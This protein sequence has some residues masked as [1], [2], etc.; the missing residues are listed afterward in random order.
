M[1]KG[2]SYFSTEIFHGPL[3]KNTTALNRE[4]LKEVVK[5]RDI[6]SAG[7]RWSKKNYPQGYTSYSSMSELFRVSSTFLKLK[8]IIDRQVKAYASELEMDLDRHALEM[9][10]LWV[11]VVPTHG[12]H[13]LHLHPHSTVSG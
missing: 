12:Y 4:L 13:G 11:N 2:K 9:T 3:A 1:S 5:I 10:H 8:Q 6:D 7:Q